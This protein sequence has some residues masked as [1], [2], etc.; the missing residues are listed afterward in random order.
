MVASGKSEYRSPKSEV[1]G[2]LGLVLLVALF[3]LAL[4]CRKWDNPL[5][6]TGDHPP[7][8]PSYPS[9]TDLGLGRVPGLV[10]HWH[11]QDP[12]S[13][14]TAYFNIFLGTDSPPAPTRDSWTDTT[15]Q[16]TGV[17][18]SMQYYWQVVAYD[19]HGDTAIGAPVWRFQTAAPILVS[20]PDTGERLKTYTTDTITWTGGP[21]GAR[22]TSRAS[23]VVMRT[24][25]VRSSVNHAAVFLA[26]ADSIVIRRSTDDGMTWIRLGRGTTPGQFAWQVPAPATEYARVEVVAYVSTDTMIGTSG[27]FAIVDSAAARSRGSR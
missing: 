2:G 17:A 13:G 3:A 18:P 14:D 7:T 9:P 8:V 24:D 25:G 5:D 20:A 27:R 16:P 12:D 15:F 21:S 4:T 22:R 11:S 19:N 6:P 23:R 1:A 26:A 10:L